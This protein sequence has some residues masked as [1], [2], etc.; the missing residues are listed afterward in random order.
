MWKAVRILCLAAALAA[1]LTAAAYTGNSST[2]KFH[3]DTCSAAQRI[4]AGNKVHFDTRSEAINAG[5][6]PCK[7]CSL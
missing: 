6:V 4:K 1:P 5:Y 3:V 2:R 7:K